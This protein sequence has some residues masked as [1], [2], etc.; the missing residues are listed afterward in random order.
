MKEKLARRRSGVEEVMVA[1]DKEEVTSGG[2]ALAHRVW[3]E[4]VDHRRCRQSKRFIVAGAV[5]TM[6]E[7]W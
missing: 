7:G 5:G 1:F 4:E 2:V 3:A 6:T